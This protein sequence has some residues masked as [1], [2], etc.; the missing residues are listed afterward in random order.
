LLFCRGM[1]EQPP[2]VVAAG[3]PVWHFPPLC[4][5]VELVRTLLLVC[6]SSRRAWFSFCGI[7]C[8]V[9][10]MVPVPKALALC[11][12]LLDTMWSVLVPPPH[13]SADGL[14]M[15]C[16]DIDPIITLSF[17]TCR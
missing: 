5:L 9:W 3:L 17:A 10:S 16:T 7:R 8:E 1:V 11:G 2:Y 6:P 12:D 13:D 14:C 4:L 15:L